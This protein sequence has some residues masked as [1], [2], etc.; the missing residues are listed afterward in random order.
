[1][2]NKR[3]IYYDTGQCQAE[4]SFAPRWE[5]Y[6]TPPS[7]TLGH[8]RFRSGVYLCGRRRVSAGW[9]G[10]RLHSPGSTECNRPGFMI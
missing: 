6:V 7:D 5:I 2:K 4:A 9:P 8:S 10:G 1:M 3:Y